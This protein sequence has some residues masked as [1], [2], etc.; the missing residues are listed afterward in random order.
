LTLTSK[1][2]PTGAFVLDSGRQINRTQSL[3]GDF[4]ILL[5]ITMQV[6]DGTLT[7]MGVQLFGRSIEANPLLF[8]LMQTFGDGAGLAAAKTV[9]LGLG[10]FLHLADVHRAVAVLVAIYFAAAV[11]PWTHLLFF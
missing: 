6:L 1:V 4:A 2:I 8:W 11:A 10:A 7:Y 5:F 9:A 3:F